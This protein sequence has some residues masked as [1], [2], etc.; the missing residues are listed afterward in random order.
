MICH[1][2]DGISKNLEGVWEGGSQRL[3]EAESCKEAG[4][5]G[6]GSEDVERH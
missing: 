1:N 2:Y 4:H 3:G 5:G 6:A